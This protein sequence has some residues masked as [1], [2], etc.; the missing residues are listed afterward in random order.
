MGELC[1]WEGGDGCIGVYVGGGWE[2][3]V[4][5]GWGMN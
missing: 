4:V 3:W 2:V 1:V 5:V